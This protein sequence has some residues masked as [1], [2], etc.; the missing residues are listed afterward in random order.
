MLGSP[1]SSLQVVVCFALACTVA[2]KDGMPDFCN[3]G[4]SLQAGCSDEFNRWTPFV[5]IRT[6]ARNRGMH[7]DDGDLLCID[8]T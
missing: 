3:F 5:T 7:Y 4:S 2:D 8:A 1:F 6:L